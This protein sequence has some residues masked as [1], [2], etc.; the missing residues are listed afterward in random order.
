MNRAKL[1]TLA[2]VFVH[3]I[4]KGRADKRYL[5]KNVFLYRIPQHFPSSATSCILCNDWFDGIAKKEVATVD[6][7]DSIIPDLNVGAIFL[8][9][10]Y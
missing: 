5:L 6:D 9:L 2:N 1:P 10:I 3:P 8:L 4:K 7:C